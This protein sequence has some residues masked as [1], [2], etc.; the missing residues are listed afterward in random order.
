[1]VWLV[2]TDY[3]TLNRFAEAVMNHDAG[4]SSTPRAVITGGHGRRGFEQDYG[5]GAD[6]AP[7]A[8]ARARLGISTTLHALSGCALGEAIG[9]AAGIARHWPVFATLGLAVTL[10]LLFAYALAALPLARSHL[11]ARSSVR[12]A[13]A[14]GTFGIALMAILAS[15]ILL[16]IPMAAAAPLTSPELWVSLAIALGIG[17]LAAYPL[18]RGMVARVLARRTTESYRDYPDPARPCKGGVGGQLPDDT[19]D[20]ILERKE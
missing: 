14:S 12:I 10:A 18:T 6:R 17:A 20:T 15:S 7:P 13:V 5:P 4:S 11:G 9:I 16:S 19:P 1:V 3:A 8:L 2:L